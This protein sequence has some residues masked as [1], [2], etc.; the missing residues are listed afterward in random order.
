[1]WKFSHKKHTEL[2]LA[3]GWPQFFSILSTL[4]VSLFL[5]PSGPPT[6]L[7]FLSFTNSSC[8]SLSATHL[9]S[10]LFC[11]S[12]LAPP[13]HFD[14]CV[15]SNS[16]PSPWQGRR[17]DWNWPPWQPSP[18]TCWPVT[19]PSCRWTSRWQCLCRCRLTAAWRRTTTS[20][21]GDLTLV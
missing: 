12:S 11:E 13:L 17:R 2:F 3:Y 1:M 8:L 10:Q 4:A 15:F 6:F 14:F 21:L 16:S 5:S 18:C 9:L 7:L 20:L 19:A